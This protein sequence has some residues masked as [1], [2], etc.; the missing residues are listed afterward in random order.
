ML[1][2]ILLLCLLPIGGVQRKEQTSSPN[3]SLISVKESRN[4]VRLA[5]PEKI[6]H[7]P[8]F[9]L[10]LSDEDKINPPRCL[11]FDV[12]WSNPG[13]GSVHVGFWAVDRRTGEVW[14]IIRCRR[15]SNAK[16]SVAQQL[17]RKRVGVGD[18]EHQ[19][20]LQK[21]PCCTPDMQETN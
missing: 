15:V 6:K 8:G 1:P 21:N 9:T 13:P 10:W 18:L 12:L 17:I 20:A 5:L 19:D 11:V 16:L 3:S 7:L 2:L 4:L 14:S